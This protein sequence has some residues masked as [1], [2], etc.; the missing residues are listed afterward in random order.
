MIAP[1]SRMLSALAGAASLLAMATVAQA[2]YRLTILHINDLHSRIEPISKYD[3]TCSAE[4]DAAGECFGGIARIKTFLDERR[5]AL[6]DQN[7]LTLDAGDQ[8]QGSLY[9]S[10]YKGAA[11]VEFMNQIGFDAMAVGNHEFDDGPEVLAD[12]IAKAQFPVI[13][14]NTSVY[15]EPALKDRLPGYVIVEEG[16]EKIGI[17]SVLATDTDETASPGENVAFVDEIRY[18]QSTIPEVE[19]QGTNKIIVLSHVGL[20]KDMEI[21]AAVPGIDVIVGGHSHTYLSASDPSR[22]GAYPTWVTGPDGVLV[23][24]VQAY[25]YSK[26]VGE[27]VV[28]FDDQGQVLFA[29]GD[30]NLIDASVAKDPA[31]DALVQE[32]GAPIQQLMAKEIGATTAPIDGDRASCRAQECEMGVLVA[33]A[34]LDKTAAQGVTIAIQNGGGLRASIDEGTVTMGEVLTVLPFQNTVAT[35]KL[36][37]ADVIAALENGV[38]QIEDGAGRFPQVAGMRYTFDPKSEPG[39]RIKSVEVETE[40]GFAPIDVDAI[41][42]VVSNN[43]MRSGGDGYKVFATNGIDAYDFGPGLEQVVAD[44][45]A[46]NSPYTPTLRGRVIDASANAAPAATEE[47]TEPEATAEAEEAAPAK[48]EAMVDSG[49]VYVVK[50]GDTLWNIARQQLGDATLYTK[51]IELNGLSPDVTLAIGQSLKMPQ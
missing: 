29:E 33:E 6:A 12:F 7:V 26:Y 14:G 37:G 36:K 24:I 49:A 9:Y 25:A 41:Y 28:D 8:F 20:R 40:D 23:P 16:G 30:T 34:M 32:L 31:F 1:R 3:G 2:E 35:F 39:S 43:Y 46:A 19:S 48:V 42:G 51:I 10:T 22:A 15:S 44:Y 21:A 18:L 5:A 11:A 45:V 4:D 13:S 47:A 50:P 38:S 27:L 17:I